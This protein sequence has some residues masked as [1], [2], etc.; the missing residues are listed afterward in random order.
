MEI[1][2]VNVSLE[3]MTESEYRKLCD[4]SLG[5]A[6]NRVETALGVGDRLK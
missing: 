6:A 4:D 2:V 3:V 5:P 1:L